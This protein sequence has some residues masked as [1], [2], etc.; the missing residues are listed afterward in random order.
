MCVAFVLGD[1][2]T[3]AELRYKAMMDQWHEWGETYGHVKREL[4]DAM[5]DGT[6]FAP[7]AIR[8]QRIEAIV[9]AI[10][11]SDWVPFQRWVDRGR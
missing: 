1:N 6:S 9:G 3:E 2:P 5:F 11:D 4:K 7:K 10:A 8:R